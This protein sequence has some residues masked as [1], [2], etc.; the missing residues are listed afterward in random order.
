MFFKGCFF[1]LIAASVFIVSFLLKSPVP[2]IIFFKAIPNRL[3]IPSSPSSEKHVSIDYVQSIDEYDCIRYSCL[4]FCFAGPRADASSR[5]GPGAAQTGPPSARI[6]G[7][8]SRETVGAFRKDTRKYRIFH[9][10]SLYV[11]TSGRKLV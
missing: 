8:V 3:S 4:T 11:V 5:P 1:Y 6:K 7:T 9:E 2:M 10:F